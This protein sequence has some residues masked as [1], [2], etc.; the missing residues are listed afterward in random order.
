MNSYASLRKQNKGVLTTAVSLL[1]CVVLSAAMLFSRL[2]VF[3]AEDTR[4]YIPLTQSQGITQVLTGTVDENGVFHVAD[5][6]L[7]VPGRSPLLA[8]PL[9]PIDKHIKFDFSKGNASWEGYTGIE[10]FK[11]SYENGEGKITVNSANG[12][13]VIAPGTTNTY[14]LALE[15][16]C[17]ENVKF[18]MEVEAYLDAN[19]SA[20]S[21]IPLE[22]KFYGGKD[23]TYF[24]GSETT[25][26]DMDK[27]HGVTDSGTLKPGYI[28]PY[29]LQW[30]WPFEGDDAYDTIL[31]NL[32]VDAEIT[33][34]IIIKTI[35]SYTPSAA[36]N[37]GIPKTGDTSHVMFYAGVMVT[38][39]AAL[40]LLFLLP[41]R[42]REEENA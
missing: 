24:V 15:N 32:S 33:L 41:K 5:E 38:S 2:T 9:R 35:A 19:I 34:T 8:A 3:A 6:V 37:S 39:A 31:G 30:Q 21:N 17:P 14:T 20:S 42:K 28:M 25:W 10:L 18:D 27:L 23:N 11:T 1:L 22:A 4:H 36:A 26:E 29:T 40:L 16:T 7:Y 13:K 12:D